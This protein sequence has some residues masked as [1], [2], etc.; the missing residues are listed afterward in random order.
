MDAD[1]VLYGI[2]GGI[3]RVRVGNGAEQSGG[4]LLTPPTQ[5]R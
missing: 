5:T 4:S 3:I 1:T 2:M